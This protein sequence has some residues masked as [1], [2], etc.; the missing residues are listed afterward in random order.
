MFRSANWFHTLMIG[1]A[2]LSHQAFLVADE[3][4][5]APKKI[6]Y[7]EQ[8]RP[9]FQAQCQGCHQP[10]KASGDYVMTTFQQ[11]L[12]GG[13]SDTA[14]IVPGKPE[15]S[16]LMDLIVPEKGKAEM[17]KGKKPLAQAEIDLIRRWIQ[18]GA[19]DDTPDSARQKYDQ[20]HPPVY[21]RPPVITSLDYS[22]DGKLLAVAGFHEVVLVSVKDAKQVARLIGVAERIEGVRFSPDG[23]RL[24]VTGGLPGRMGEIQIWDVEKRELQLSVPTTHDTVY[25]GTWSPD[26]K[27][28]AFGASD[29]T[30]RAV[31]AQTG[32]EVVYMAAHE[33]LVRST[34][35][36]NDSKSILSV[37]RDK[38]VKMTE[39][40][41]QR[42][43]GNVTTHTPG[44]LQGGQISIDRH[45]KRMEVLVGGADGAPK[46]FRM[47]VKAAPAKGGNPNQI[48]AYP[49]MKGRVFDVRIRPDGVWGFATASLDG[50]S[51]I[52]AYEIDSGKQVWNLDVPQSG[53]YALA[54][55]PDGKALAAA[56]SDGKIRL[57]DAV[58]GRVE[59]EL[60]PIELSQGK[61]N[62]RGLAVSVDAGVE[63]PSTKPLPKEFQIVSLEAN[64]ASLKFA[65]PTDYAQLLLFAKDSRGDVIDVTRLAKWSVQ[66]NVGQV[67]PLGL[68]TP[69]QNGSGTVVGE[70]KGRRVEVPVKVTGFDTPYVPDFVRDVTPLISKVGC[71]AGTCHGAAKGKNGFKL[72]LRGYDAILDVRGFTDDLASRRSNVAAPEQSLMLLKATA[73][74]PHVGGQVI[75]PNSKYYQIVRDWIGAGAELNLKT[76]RVTGI[77]ILPKNPVIQ[78][79]GSKQQMRVVATYADGRTRDVTREAHI[80]SGNTEVSEADSLGILSALRRGEAPVL[81]RYEGAYAATTLTVMGN[82]DGFVWKAP[83][84]WGPVDELVS[85]KWQRV[86]ILPSEL[87]TDAEFIRRVSLDLTGLPPTPQQVKAFVADKRE[88]QVKRNALIDQLIGSDDFIEYWTN[89]WADLLQVNRKFLAPEGAAAFRK[90]IRGEVSAN[91]PYDQFV[92]KVLTA[93]GSNR[94]NPPASY[95][96]ILRDPLDTMENTTQLFLGV[97]FSCNKCHDHPFERWTQDQYYQTA[98]YFAQFG[99]KTDPASGKR[100]IGGTAVEGAKPL[101]E[102]VFDKTT[103]DV[104]HDRTKAITPPQFPFDCDYESPEKA[105]RRQQFVAWLTSDTNPYFA[106]SYVNRLWGY[107]LGA[108]IIEPVDDI[109]AGNPATNPELLEYLTAQFVESE[110]DIRHMLRLICTSRTYQLSLATHRWNEDDSLNY[111][112]AVA[113]RLPAE[114]L[115]DSIHRVTGTKSNLPG[116]PAGSR[117]AILPDSGIK[118]PD[119]FLTTL[120]RPARESACECERTSGLQLGPVMALVSGP[121]LGRA[122][123]DGNND[124]T[125]LAK[126]ELDDAQLIE[127]LFLRILSRS[128]TQQEI[129]ASLKVLQSLPAEHQ[130]LV[131]ALKDYEKKL[132]PILAKKEKQ[133]QDAI[134]K[135]KS[136]LTNYEKE[137]AARETQLD[138]E[139]KE[140]IAKATAAL[141]AYEKTL[142]NALARWEQN[143]SNGSSWTVVEASE[144][145]ATHNAKLQQEKDGAIFV[146]GPNGKGSYKVVAKTELA[147]VTGI[148]LEALTDKRLPSKGP[149]R[150]QNGNFVLTEFRVEWSPANNAGQKKKVSLQNAKADFS[151]TGYD[152]KTA[153][154][155]KEA[156]TGNG[157]ATAPKFGQTRTAVIETKEDL[158][159]GILTFWLDQKYQDS[160]HT[161][162]RFRL[163]LSTSARPLSLNG[164]PKAIADVLAIP[165]AKRNPKQKADLLKYFRGVDNE[166]KKRLEAVANAKKPRPVDPKLTMLRNRLALA[167]QPLPVDPQLA[168]LRADVELSTNQM[169]SP[170]LTFA[171][172]LTWALI[173][174]PAFL[175]NR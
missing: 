108:G 126:S 86:K 32:K 16:Y 11:L 98:A 14:A 23:K 102:V 173:N 29:N 56:G 70:L 79:E 28:I 161:I 39:I 141:K 164:P 128:A 135:A 127:E 144:L 60:L 67:S 113:R 111:S 147:G 89:K 105:T 162:G 24:A 43:L 55:S 160:Q 115:Y 109:R 94:E 22:P 104:T 166:M 64:P 51:Q 174:N 57:I 129:D 9:I 157:W 83:E 151:Q 84:T 31:D 71:N 119:R 15:T 143:L 49:A 156:A 33:D 92:K 116:L 81:A 103:G 2:V 150:A 44:V 85:A 112:H 48:R 165:A 123:S 101:Y 169:K 170:R 99:L 152:V 163:S 133:R 172:D 82:R 62:A 45:P 25:G 47:D 42:F 130:K 7:Y 132:A 4:E 27:L 10:A 131:G 125:K 50:K 77:E 110:F 95:F 138:K 5:T 87:C 159:P 155:G 20:D 139:Q 18:E 21:T 40:A 96:K 120:G 59:N 158:G 88:T 167:E 146:S 74:V 148:K 13:E 114:V 8:I 3:S 124:I 106:R 30:L 52:R 145:S 54:V 46:L 117:A 154:D 142:P 97:R 107:L 91:T 68:F 19:K 149:G 80:E 140:R 93:T 175:F 12:K 63:T 153:I 38:T 41:T 58:A 61:A 171:Q 65:T 35:F 72:S 121:T 53:T 1:V 34:V 134:A 76:P 36:S 90:W 118:L 137:I 6:S 168:Q 37:S 69:A 73:A 17:P 100:K 78:N 26:G 75:K 136:N 122:I 66:G